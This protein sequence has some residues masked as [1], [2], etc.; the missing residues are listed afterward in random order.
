MLPELLGDEGHEGVE[1]AEQLVEELLRAGKRF[2]VDGALVG[3]LH[4]LEVPAAEVIPEEFVEPLEGLRDAVAAEVCLQLGDVA[5]HDVAEP[6]DGGGVHLALRERCVDLPA[7]DQTV[8]VPD[9]VAEVAALLAERLVEHHVV[10]GRR[11]EQHRHAHAVGAVLCDEVQRVGRVAQL[12]GHLAADFVAHDAREVD[13]AE[14]LLVAVFVSRHNHAGHPEEDD[15]GARH[16]VVGGVVVFDFG[17]MRVA[18]A[19]EHRDGP[20]PRREPRVE[21]VVVLAQVLGPQRGVA[22]L[23]AGL[24]ERLFER[25]GHHVAALGEVVGRDALA[26]PQLARDAPVL[27]VLHPVAVGVL[28]LLGDEADGILHDGLRGRLGQLLHREEPLHRELGLDGHARALRIA[29]VVRILLGLFEQAGRIEV[30]LDLAAY[31]EAVLSHVH[32]H[33]VVHRAVVVEDVDDLEVV[34][35]AQHVVV[36]VMGRGDLQRAGSELDVDI[37]VADDRNRAADQ[38]HDDA[39]VGRQ[40]GV[41][42]VIGVDAERRIAQNGLGT[43]RGHD[44]VLLRTFDFV[45][46]VVELAVRLLEDHLLV[47]ESRFCGGVPVDHPHAAVDFPLLVEVAE[48]ADDAFGA[49]LVHREAGALPVARG[50][51]L[52]QLAQNH[53]AVLLLPLPGV[54][55]ELLAGEL[56]FFDA[57]FVEHRHHLCLGGNR[58]VVHARHPA[59]VAARHAG[60]AHQHV[61]QRVVEHVAHVEHTRNVGGRDDDGIGLTCVG[62]RVEEPMLNPEVVPFGLDFLRRVFVCELHDS[63]FYRVWRA[64]LLTICQR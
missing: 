1:Q 11:R 4:Q 22:R 2:G 58:G 29:D 45:A 53:A 49:G 52:A 43:R 5:A 47:R 54:A 19:V 59:G 3:G 35:L 31:V 57:L 26:P 20:E 21:H 7:V 44:D 46:Q 24:L 64:K 60:T 8:G 9:F 48:D 55:E 15:V 38:R 34:L 27:D 32:A 50:A 16:Q 42:R 40:R 30:L 18:D 6:L 12:L 33:L 56:R 63:S 61:L 25:L 36:Y 13:V 39:G 23:G 41:T 14:G 28:V 62:L 51:Q 37:F 17:V 10:A